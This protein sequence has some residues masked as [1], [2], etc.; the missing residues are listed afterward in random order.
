MIKLK[1]KL[2]TPNRNWNDWILQLNWNKLE[3]VNTISKTKGKK[4]IQFHQ[5]YF[6]LIKILERL[7]GL[8]INY[9]KN[10]IKMII[11]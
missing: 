11:L 10:Y 7:I 5:R 1:N 2:Y 9:K 8:A 6:I 4:P 3:W